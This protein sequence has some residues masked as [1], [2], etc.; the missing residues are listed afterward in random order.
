MVSEF[1]EGILSSGEIDRK[2]LA[3]V[4]FSDKKAL[5]KLEHIV[6]PAAIEMIKETFETIKDDSK[7]TAF[8]V[9]FPLLFEIGFD[10]WFDETVT[11]A[12]DENESKA[13]FD[14]AFGA[15]AFEERMQRQLPQ[16]EKI[17]RSNVV[18]KNQGSPQ[19]LERAVNKW[20]L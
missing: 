4:V 8:V 1:G 17:K 3:R 5:E 20:V 2:K 7:Y 19:E 16:N 9:E 10:E 11:V 6:H 18:I 14:H 15:G 13:R 12:C